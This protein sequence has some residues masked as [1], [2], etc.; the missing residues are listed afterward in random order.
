MEGTTDPI[1]ELPALAPPPTAEATM[2]EK[3]VVVETSPPTPGDPESPKTVVDKTVGEKTVIE[4][5]PPTPGVSESPK[6]APPSE[7]LTF[8]KHG[9]RYQPAEQRK[10]KNSLLAGVG[11]LELANAG[12]F[13]ANVWN[14]VPVKPWVM[15]LMALGGTVALGI[16][17]YAFRDARL[18]RRNL[19]VLR[20]ERRYLQAQKIRYGHDR[21][22]GRGLEAQLEVNFREMGTEWVD[23]VGMDS[24]MGFGALL[25]GVGTFMAIGALNHNVFI[26]SNLLSGYIG[27]GLCALYGISNMMWSAYVWR[28]AHRHKVAGAR[29]LNGGA[30]DSMLQ[31]RI[32][33]VQLHASVN[34]ITGAVAGAASLVTATMWWGYVVLVP[35]IVLSILMNYLFRHRI[36]YD[37]PLAREV[38]SMDEESLAKELKF[39]ASVQRIL[40]K[41][42]SESLSEL[43]PDP[44][45]L[46]CVIYFI[47]ENQLF[48]DFCLRVLADTELSVELLGPYREAMEIDSQSLLAADEA[49][50]PRL[51]EMAQETVSNRGLTC[52]NYRERY[53]LETLGCYFCTSKVMATPEM[54]EESAAQAV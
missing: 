21:D 1:R 2:L 36:G 54:A 6:T 48:D 33:T 23:R 10:L 28:R 41:G 3:T 18:S 49:S 16:I 25:V 26:A 51:L 35:C 24:L 29:D 37:R 43:V 30:V 39:V 34:A 46:D 5:S 11:F 31:N 9:R 14:E 27:N 4:T 53:L 45:V 47:A 19:V 32:S 20:D 13:A 8:H 15:A 50:V 40:R 52:F 12:D 44:N 42:S 7:C 22:V 17:Y 38:P